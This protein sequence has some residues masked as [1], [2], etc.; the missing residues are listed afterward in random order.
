MRP[1]LI[2]YT[3]CFTFNVKT[4]NQEPKTI[5]RQNKQTNKGEKKRGHEL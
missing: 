4:E 1:T 3:G 5:P 2:K